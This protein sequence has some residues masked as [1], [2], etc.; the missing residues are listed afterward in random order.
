MFLRFRVFLNFNFYVYTR[1]HDYRNL[2]VSN[3]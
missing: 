2:R 1:V 3:E